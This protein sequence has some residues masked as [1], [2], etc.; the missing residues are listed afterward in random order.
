MKRLAVI[1]V[2]AIVLAALWLNRS[3]FHRHAFRAAATAA[4]EMQSGKKFNSTTRVVERHILND[5][6]QAGTA[7]VGFDGAQRYLV[8]VENRC[9]VATVES[10]QTPSIPVP[11]RYAKT[12]SLTKYGDATWSLDQGDESCAAVVAV[13]NVGK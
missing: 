10:R 13:R 9:D 8:S 1:V 5:V 11:E 6:Q 12:I 4:E 3:Q 2:V 7:F